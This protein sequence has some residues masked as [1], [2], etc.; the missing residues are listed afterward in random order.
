[1]SWNILPKSVLQYFLEKL[2]TKFLLSKSNDILGSKNILPFPYTYGSGTVQGLTVTVNEDGSVKAQGTPTQDIAFPLNSN[3]IE[4]L[5]LSVGDE[6]IFSEW[7]VQNQ[8]AFAALLSNGT[9]ISEVRGDYKLTITSELVQNDVDFILY[10]IR[11]VNLTTPVTFKPMIRLATDTDHTW[12][13]PALTNKILTD[14][15]VYL[16]YSKSHV[17]ANPSTTTGTLTGIEIDG[18]TYAVQGGGHVIK[19]D[20]GTSMTARDNVQF[21]GTYVSDDSANDKTVVPII[22]TMDKTDFDLLSQDEKKGLIDVSNTGYTPS[23]STR[24][25]DLSDCSIIL[26]GNGQV[27][28]YDSSTNKWVNA[29][30]IEIVNNLTTNDATKA[31]SAA[32]GK[33]LKDITDAIPRGTVTSVSGGTGL[34]GTVTESGSIRTNVPRVNKDA[35]VDTESLMNQIVWEE[36]SNTSTNIPTTNTWYHIITIVGSDKQYATQLALGMTANIAYYRSK[37]AGTWQTWLKLTP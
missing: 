18:N 1:M 22:R 33:A 28:K 17:S 10:F 27:L 19:N 6:L 2:K 3:L 15:V 29:D 21:K 23:P 11:G 13:S 36:F 37:Q 25:L 4:D 9:P 5:N 8:N 26:P 31:L 24:L 20:S 34:T 30:D 16:N 14:R 12:H 7:E 35:N 32:Q